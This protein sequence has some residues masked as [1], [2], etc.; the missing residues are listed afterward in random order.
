M[1]QSVRTVASIMF[2]HLA[3][4][5]GDDILGT[6]HVTAILYLVTPKTSRMIARSILSAAL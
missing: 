2:Q 1:V 3:G 4:V 5:E 6:V